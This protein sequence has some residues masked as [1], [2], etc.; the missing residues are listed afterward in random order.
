[1]DTKSVDIASANTSYTFTF[2]SDATFSK[3]D[4]ISIKIQPTTDPVAAGVVGTFVLEF[5]LTT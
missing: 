5:D 2:D 3:G 4:A 1:M